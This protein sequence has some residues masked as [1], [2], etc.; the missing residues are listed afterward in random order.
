MQ[1]FAS[2]TAA[3][4][5][6]IGKEQEAHDFYVSLSAKA[7]NPAMGQALLD[8]AQEELGHKAKLLAVKQ[9][10]PLMSAQTK[11]MDLKI[12]DYLV[13]VSA[14]GV[15]TYQQ[16][17]I[18]AMKQEKAAYKLYMDIAAACTDP[19]TQE[20]FLALANEEAKHKLRFELEY[21]EQVLREN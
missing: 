18:V 21:D 6:A 3:L 12:G 4:D 16:A 7:T 5:F 10:Q 8:F 2:V 20:L 13:E 11:V 9:G 19:G 17:L 1:T 14:D 15:H